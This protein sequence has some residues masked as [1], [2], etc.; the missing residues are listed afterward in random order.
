MHK[1]TMILKCAGLVFAIQQAISQQCSPKEFHLKFNG[2]LS[3]DG[4]QT[5]FSANGTSFGNAMHKCINFCYEDQRC[6]G[7][8]VCELNPE[9]FKCRVCCEWMKLGNHTETQPGCKYLET[10][11]ENGENLAVTGELST[12]F[13]EENLFNGSNAVDGVTSCNIAPSMAANE[14]E[15]A[16]WL[17]IGLKE[18]VRVWK[19]LLYNRQ[20]Y[21]DRLH[22]VSVNVTGNE[23]NH[24]CG[25]YP[26]PGGNGDQLLFLCKNGIIGDTVTITIQAKEGQTEILNLCEVEVFAHP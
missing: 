22:D 25:F 26:G 14:S 16:S 8:E 1:T 24:L 7:V 3:V 17:R 4:Y 20:S 12:I 15:K 6:I 11:D 5:I 13:D 19:V 21:G 2:K 18:K 23:I 9:L 10:I